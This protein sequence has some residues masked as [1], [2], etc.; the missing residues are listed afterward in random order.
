MEYYDESGNH[1]TDPDL[2]KGKVTYQDKVRGTHKQLLPG[3][4]Q[5]GIDGKGLY[6]EITDHETIGIYHAYTNEEI[7]QQKADAE[8]KA[9]E[10]KQAAAISALPAQ[11]T[12]LQS[13]LCDVYEQLLSK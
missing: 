12:Q 2:S 7:A 6:Q 8:A 3:T 13:A 11:M 1:I 9:A 10:E 4:E 5:M